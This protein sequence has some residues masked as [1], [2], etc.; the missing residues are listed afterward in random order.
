MA[1]LNICCSQPERRTQTDWT[2]FINRHQDAFRQSPLEQVKSYVAPTWEAIVDT[3]I[4]AEEPLR[5]LLAQLKPGGHRAR[6]RRD[7]SGDRQ[8]PASPWVR[9]V[10][11][12]ETEIP[13]PLVPPISPAVAVERRHGL[14][15]I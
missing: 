11:C 9:V 13:D 14:D 7:V 5:Q 4:A 1:F 2:D 15:G 3:A 8:S 12:A 6:Q 10:S